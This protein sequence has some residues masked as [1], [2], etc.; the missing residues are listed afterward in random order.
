MDH[1]RFADRVAREV[2]DVR[3]GSE[4]LDAISREGFW[5]VVATFEGEVTA[6]RFGDVSRAT[7]AAPP[8]PAPVAWRPL[9][10]HWC[11][12][13]DRAA[14]VGAVREVRERIAAGTV[15]QVNV[16]RVL[17]HELAAD[18]DLDGLDA[19]LRQGNPA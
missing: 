14:Y 2:V 12:S 10:R 11:T 17:S 15:Y 18:A 19:L 4:A 1:A 9:D 8:P 5:A 6:V 16:C 3:R 13:L 7:P